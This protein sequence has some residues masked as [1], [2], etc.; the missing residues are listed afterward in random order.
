MTVRFR[1]NF[2]VHHF[3][4]LGRGQLARMLA[5]SLTLIGAAVAALILR[6]NLNGVLVL[7]PVDPVAMVGFFVRYTPMLLV[8]VLAVNVS[9][10]V[11]SD[12]RR[13]PLPLKWRNTALALACA[14][15]LSLSAFY[16]LHLNT[17]NRGVLV[18]FWGL[19]VAGMVGSRMVA[20]WVSR[21]YR[22]ESRRRRQPRENDLVAVIGGAGYL[23]S[24]L[25]DRLLR[26]GY[27]VRVLDNLTFGEAPLR[28]FQGNPR[29][30]L[31]RGDYRNVAALLDTVRDAASVV[32]LGGIVGDPACALNPQVT[33]SHNLYANKAIVSVCKGLGVSR[34]VF[35]SSCSVYGA[36]HGIMRETS[37]TAPVS[38][39]AATKLDSEAMMLEAEDRH[40][41]PVCLRFATVFGL[42]PRP[43]FDLV[44]NLFSA[45]AVFDGQI[46]VI[47]PHLQRPFVHTRDIAA[48]VQVVLESPAGLVAGQ[49]FNVGSDAINH[50]IGEL[51]EIIRE[52]VPGTQVVTTTDSSDPR[53]YRV[54][55][56]KIE[57]LGFKSQVLLRDGITEIV[58]ACRNGAI[59]EYR[60]TVY[61]NHR[62]LQEQLQP[63]WQE[64]NDI[65]VSYSERFL[66]ARA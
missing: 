1:P 29:F 18:L 40:F 32:H 13:L 42:S 38:L 30:N 66:K 46:R 2:S 10:G 60:D 25:V 41:F 64:E 59:R 52:V 61:N 62:F 3:L 37:P 31:V 11:Y 56:E 49:I 20:E 26:D 21:N 28:A 4:H 45:Q 14:I 47:N 33:M 57:R 34:L 19:A 6:T 43:R 48:A 65:P 36:A 58:T 16:L 22:V 5:D 23:G 8:L 39:Y 35:A 9:F 51:G 50:S 17:I 24:V 63:G 55:F 53:S 15:T 27:R 7:K 54:S 44:V 12:A